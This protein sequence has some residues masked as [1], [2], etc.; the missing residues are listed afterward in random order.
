MLKKRNAM[1]PIRIRSENVPSRQL[2]HSLTAI[3]AIDSDQRLA[4]K[5]CCQKSSIPLTYDKC[6]A[7]RTDVV[8]TCDP[9]LLQRVPERDRFERAIPGRDGI[10]AHNAAQTSARTGVS[11]TRSASAVRWSVVVATAL[12][13]RTN[14]YLRRQSAVATTALKLPDALRQPSSN[15]LTL[16]QMKNGA[17][18]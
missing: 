3:H 2:E 16:T 8:E 7:R 14:A 4:L 17:A 1:N 6:A 12:C 10:E 11:R 15:A 9:S 13:R 18:G 5:K